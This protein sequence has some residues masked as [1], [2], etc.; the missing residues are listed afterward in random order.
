MSRGESMKLTSV[1]IS[2]EDESSLLCG[3]SGTPGPSKQATFEEHEQKSTK[4]PPPQERDY[5]HSLS[6]M[7]QA[8]VKD[9]MTESESEDILIPEESV[10]QEEIAEEVET[11]ICEC[12]EEN[13]KTEHEFSEDPVNP[14]ATNYETEVQLADSSESCVVMNDVID[15]LS[16]IEIKVELKSESPQE[17]MSVVIDQLEDCVSP[18]QSASSINSVSDAAGKDP[19]STKELSTSETQ[20]TSLEGSLFAAG[21]I[22]VDMELQSDPEERLSENACISETSFSSESP[23]GPCVSIASPGGDTQSTSEEPCTPASLETACSSEVSSTEN[24]DAD[25]QQK[26]SDENLHTPLMS[27]ISP[28]STSPVTSEASLMSNLPLT[29]EASPASNLPLTSETSP[30]SDVPLTSETSSVSSVLLTSETSLATSLPLPSET[31]PISNSPRSERLILQQRKSPC[32][33]EESLPILREETSSIPKVPQEENLVHQKQF[34]N[35]PENM[36]VGPQTIIPEMSLLEESQSKNLSHQSCKSHSEIEKSYVVSIPEHSSPE[37]IKIKNNVQQR[38]EKKNTLSPSEVSVLSEATVGKN[39]ELL[40][41]KPQDKLY[42]SSLEKASFSEVCRS[43]AYKPP[44]NAQSRLEN[45]HSSKS[46]EPTKS[47]EVRNETRDPEIPK[48]KTAEQH[49]FGICKEK[50]ARIEDDLS[51]RNALL[52][53]PFEKEQPPREEP[54]VPPL[55]VM[56]TA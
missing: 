27:E 13:H 47:P 41:S 39:S 26:T 23:E 52:T 29:S 43:K 17:E 51:N 48:R 2:N 53:S 8:P 4:I 36:K 16:H 6:N 10:I 55:K 25:S 20:S 37:V 46:L 40:P 34:Q 30:M 32:L 35:I 42:T 28:M 18:A 21:G 45:S 3:S 50:R 31:S 9:L 38:A 56:L 14:S 1:Q 12:Q 44:T 24:I 49:S 5:C 22:A 54:R 11:S 7:E 15:T 33:S 19:E